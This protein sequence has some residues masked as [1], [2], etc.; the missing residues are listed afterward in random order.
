MEK[1][2]AYQ[3]YDNLT[4][5]ERRMQLVYIMHDTTK[6]KPE[7]SPDE[8]C[9]LLGYAWSTIRNYTYKYYYLLEKAKE[10]FCTVVKKIICGIVEKVPIVFAKGTKLCYLFKFYDSK[11]DLL[12]SKV[13]TTERRLLTRLKEEMRSY[14]KAGYDIYGVTIESV[15]DCGT[16][17]PEGA[18]SFARAEFIARNPKSFIKND[19]FYQ[20][21]IPTED[22]N[23]CVI[24]Y[25]ARFN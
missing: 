3:K 23:N 10:K 7:L 12:F 14:D 8:K 19:R 20:Y 16:A 1:L 13:G 11:G 24:S 18:E 9:D 17:P 15:F 6:D 5:E 2:D 22:F 25:L 21:D 4:T